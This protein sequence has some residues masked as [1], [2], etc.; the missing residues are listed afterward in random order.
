MSEQKFN[1]DDL[2]KAAQKFGLSEEAAS[3]A[4]DPKKRD[5]ILSR[6]SQKDRD[7]VSEVLNNPEMTKKLL[8]SPQAQSL[9]KNLFGDKQNG[10]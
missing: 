3:K 4:V 5:E 1:S 2:L 10:N 6:L 7:K 9:I 8:S